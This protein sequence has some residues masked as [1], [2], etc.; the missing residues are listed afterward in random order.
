MIDTHSHLQF[1]AFDA[2]RAEVLGRMRA[3]GVGAAVVV[4]CDLESSRAAIAL[5]EEHDE[6]YATVGVHPNDCGGWSEAT[7]DSLRALAAHERVVAI[8]E[9]GL[10]YYRDRVD[11]ET[12][13]RA[14]H[15]Q[16]ELAMELELPLVVHDRDAH[17]DVVAILESHAAHGLRAVM[18]CF[19]GDA[20]LAL[21][22]TAA[23]LIV[24][25]AGP[26]SYR[27][28]TELR[29]AAAMVPADQYVIETDCPFL[30]PQARRGKRN[31]PAYVAYVADTIAEARGIP[32]T[33]VHEQSTRNAC[34]LF[35]IPHPKSVVS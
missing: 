25:F 19:S 3:A 15:G 9:S 12:Q 1:D 31:E 35:G 17:D 30:A 27:K 22:A 16:A 7:R 11:R 28:N 34:R 21:R 24:S 33:Q 18:H 29:E 4:G 8:G 23:G 5:A 2:D 20:T 10:D 32:V 6:I 26:V 13:H 14:F